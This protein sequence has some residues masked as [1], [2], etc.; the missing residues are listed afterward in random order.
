M[1]R[2][3]AAHPVSIHASAREATPAHALPLK[4][5]GVSIHASAREATSSIIG[6]WAC[7]H[8]F[9]PRLRAGGDVALF[10]LPPSSS[11]FNPRLRAGGDPGALDIVS[12]ISCFNP[13]LRAGGD[14]VSCRNVA[15]TPVSIHASAREATRSCFWQS[16][17][18]DGFNPR[19]RAGGD[20][21]RWRSAPRWRSSF[22]PRLRAGGDSAGSHR[23]R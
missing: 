10:K 13:R 18:H 21:R 8:S 15:R 2:W 7:F 4:V 14:S 19:L 3:S 16:V 9:N 11:C 17:A 22:N 1:A 23:F 5:K 6:A 20:L 12:I